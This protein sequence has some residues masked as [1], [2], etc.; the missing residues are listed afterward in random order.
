MLYS[1]KYIQDQH[2]IMLTVYIYTSYDLLFFFK[3]YIVQ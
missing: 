1:Y 2:D 3:R